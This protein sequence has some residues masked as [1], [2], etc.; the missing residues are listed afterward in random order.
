MTVTQLVRA[1]I[2]REKMFKSKGPKIIVNQSDHFQGL[3]TR[4]N[5]FFSIYRFYFTSPPQ[6]MPYNLPFTKNFKIA[7]NLIINLL[8]HLQVWCRLSRAWPQ[9]ELVII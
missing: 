9:P 6:K 5:W 3:T 4:C 8:D 2:E 1:I 7:L